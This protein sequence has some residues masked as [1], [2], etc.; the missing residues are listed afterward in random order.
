[1]RCRLVAGDDQ[2]HELSPYGDVRQV[3]ALDLGFQ[4]AGEKVVGRRRVLPSGGD[5]GIDVRGEFRVGAGQ[6]DTA[7]GAVEGGIGPLH[8]VIAPA[9]KLLPVLPGHADQ[10]GDDVDRDG[11]H[12]VGDQIAVT[13]A[14]QRVQVL[15]AQ[16]ADERLEAHGLVIR[17]AGID[18][19]S[20]PAVAGLDYLVY[21]LLLFGHHHARGAETGHE[22]VHLANGLEHL[23]LSRQEPPDGDAG[24]GAVAAHRPELLVRDMVLGPEGIE[25]YVDMIA[26]CHCNVPFA[27]LPHRSTGYAISVR[28]ATG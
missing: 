24:H 11:H 27:R 4:Q 1:M 23:G 8:Y 5:E 19:L 16:V 17:D 2:E 28:P 25:L 21:E 26:P 15:V 18:D 9:P 7:L 6:P 10:M 20:H 12:E 22:G 13:T 14:D 3:P